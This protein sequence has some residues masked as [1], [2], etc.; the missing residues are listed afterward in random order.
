MDP[1][2][3]TTPIKDSK[4]PPKHPILLIEDEKPIRRFVKPY[5]EIQDFKVIEAQ[6]GEEGLALA[7]SHKPELILLDLGLPD[8]DGLMVLRRLREWTKIPVII[9]TA[10]GKDQDKVEGLNA[11]ADD[12]LAKPF[13]VE[14]LMARIRVSLRHLDDMKRQGAE[15]VFQTKDFKVDL[16]ARL[17]TVKGKEIHPTPNEY[18]LL[19]ILIH[20]AGKVVTQKQIIDEIWE[21]HSADQESSLRI[22][23]HQ[24]RDK[25]E[26]DAGLPKY[27]LTEP[28]VGYRLKV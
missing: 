1:Q 15:P 9:L 11:G 3:Q 5:L 20:H 16:D 28:G 2:T 27:I 25:L 7:S 19:A 22:Y 12:Y 13:S 6:T 14:E 17:V 21:P 4:K 8:M 18:S 26:S 24:L 23:I 10:R